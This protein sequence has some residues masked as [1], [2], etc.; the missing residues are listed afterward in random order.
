VKFAAAFLPAFLLFCAPAFA[1]TA[2]APVNDAWEPEETARATDTN[3]SFSPPA[4]LFSEADKLITYYQH[5][6]S[7]HS[8]SRCPFK[9]SC[10]E[11]ARKAVAL[12]GAVG[13][14]LFVDRYLYRENADAFSHY[15]L[16]ETRLG[17]LKLDDSSYLQ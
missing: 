10:S 8:V 6:I 12:H 9:I 3:V 7:P 4:V 15:A 17:I 13:F 16:V 2:H 14:L 11:F 5:K 1:Q